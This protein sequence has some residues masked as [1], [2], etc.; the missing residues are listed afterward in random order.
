[1][2]LLT[3]VLEEQAP[4]LIERYRGVNLKV[5]QQRDGWV[6]LAGQKPNQP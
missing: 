1:V 6:L 3:G 4:P 5:N 2:I